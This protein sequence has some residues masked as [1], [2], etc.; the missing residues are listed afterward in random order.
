MSEIIGRFIDVFKHFNKIFEW[1]QEA[2]KFYIQPKSF[3]E[4]LLSIN[5]KIATRKIIEYFLFIEGILLIVSATLIDKI[6]FSLFKIPGLLILDVIIAFPLIIIISISLWVGKV[7]LP[8]KKSIFYVILLKIYFVIPLQLFFLL[9]VFFENYVFYILFGA[10]TQLLVI[11][12]ILSPSFFF[13]KKNKQ[14][15]IILCT[16]I[17]LFVS[18]CFLYSQI[19]RINPSTDNIESELSTFDPIFSEFVRLNNKARLIDEIETR[20][21][22]NTIDNYEKLIKNMDIE[23]EVSR[24]RE[25]RKYLN[26]ILMERINSEIDIFNDKDTYDFD[27]NRR[28]FEIYLNFLNQLILYREKYYRVFNIIDLYN[29]IRKDQETLNSMK[30]EI[31]GY[32]EFKITEF[33]TIDFSKMSEAEFIKRLDEEVE[34]LKIESEYKRL[35]IEIKDK[36]ISILENKTKIQEIIVNIYKEA[37]K[38]EE[39]RIEYGKEKI[40]Y[41]SF[42][43]T[44]RSLIFL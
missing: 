38:L 26:E 6:Q 39:A 37:T 27:S 18:L 15:L 9:F 7:S 4:N 43:L 30:S 36:E 21:D 1:L 16:T 33:N 8:I 2:L 24:M 20:D 11:I 13:A 14:F 28:R 17:V 42:I 41:Y 29:L 35:I 10:G 23:I 3:I 19:S 34:Q 31:E 12:L 44:I 32:P 25:D 40:N 5:I 22:M